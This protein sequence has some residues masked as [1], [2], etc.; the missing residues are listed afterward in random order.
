MAKVVNAE[1]ARTLA[2]NKRDGLLKQAI[3]ECYVAISDEAELGRF[4]LRAKVPGT[5][6]KDVV[7]HLRKEGGYSVS[8]KTP[9]G[10]DTQAIEISINWGKAE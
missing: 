10:I 6:V 5:V 4:D 9:Q 1:E 3:G 7:A 8:Y 2:E